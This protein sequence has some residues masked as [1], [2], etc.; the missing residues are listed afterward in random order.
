MESSAT[1]SKL[2]PEERLE[3]K[4]AGGGKGGGGSHTPVETPD[5]LRSKAYANVLDLVCEGPIKGPSKP[6]LEWVYLDGVP[7][8]NPDGSLNFKDVSVSWVLGTQ[9]QDYIPNFSDVEAEIPVATEVKYGTPVVRTISDTMYDQV[10]VTLSVP[11][12]ASTNVTN[13]DISGTSV[14]ILIDVQNNGAGYVNKITDTI[15]GK[16][17]NGY[18][19]SYLIKLPK[20]GGPWDIRVTRVT[21]DSGS[22]TLQN[23]TYWQRYTQIIDQ[24]FSYPNS[25]IIGISID[26]EQFQ[27]IPN[28]GYELDLLLCKVPD[29]Y[30]P[31]TRSYSGT[32]GGGW[33]IAWTNNPVWCTYDFIIATR[34]GCGRRLSEAN[35]DKYALY[36]IAQY[37]DGF[38]ATGSLKRGSYTTGSVT[39][40]ARAVQASV[41]ASMVFGGSPANTITRSSGSW[42]TDGYTVGDTILITGTAKNNGYFTIQTK[43][44][45]VLTVRGVINSE[46]VSCTVLNTRTKYQ[47]ARTTGSFITDGFIIGD[48]ITT[49]GFVIGSNNGRSRV[50]EVSALYL[51]VDERTLTNDTAAAGRTIVTQDPTE[52]RFTCNVYWQVADNAYRTISAMASIF[53]SMAYWGNNMLQFVQDA[54]KSRT[55]IFNN[56]NVKD[57]KF[58]YSS[59]GNKATHTV[60]SVE[61]VDPNNGYTAVIESV[62]DPTGIAI[63]GINPIKVQGVG[64]TSRSQ[65]QRLGRWVLFTERA[66][67]ELVTFQSAFEGMVARPGEIFGVMDN[68]RI[69]AVMSGRIK[70]CP[71]TTHVTL[72]QAVTFAV[73]NTYTLTVFLPTGALQDC[74][75][76]NPGNTTTAS[77]TLTTPLSQTVLV[78]AVFVITS[79]VL[80]PVDYRIL[81]ITDKSTESDIWYEVIGMS[82]A[83]SKFSLVENNLLLQTYGA[84]LLTSKNPVTGV[85]VGEYHVA[86]AKGTRHVV[87][88]GWVQQP[89]AKSYILKWRRNGGEWTTMNDVLSPYTEFE[90]PDVGAID[91][92]VCANYLNG[93]SVSASASY[94]MTGKN[95]APTA[96]TGLAITYTNSGLNFS[97][98]KHTDGDVI[99]YE[100]RTG[101]TAGS[102]AAATVVS[103]FW[104]SNVYQWSTSIPSNCLLYVAA[105]DAS[106]NESAASQITVNTLPAPTGVTVAF[107]TSR[108]V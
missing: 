6:G 83:S 37:C 55:M 100:I 50:L 34:Y 58:A 27:N 36:T 20:P 96:P 81:S 97:W 82:Y 61:W 39:L 46:T 53:R 43:T 66:E 18:E 14:D 67:P 32:W 80:T 16:T 54:P 74:T 3:V 26:S 5:S 76:T 72:D 13:G 108:P 12:L 84:T 95:T 17:T 99:A 41:T 7:L 38:V 79:S 9:T 106:G 73:G 89:G 47:Y 71:D 107:S 22:S 98:D 1:T 65:A 60:A 35:L 68:D 87:T 64:C 90:V 51:T 57:G 77:L 63:Y 59:A 8:E 45:L 21:A 85:T 49:T 105:I 42:I 11:A 92:S 23:K 30:D 91:V 31:L 103:N 2:S 93:V 15:R 78:N 44:D 10:R 40:S 88:V 62:E 101:P 25:A 75:I 29:N 86:S 94:T 52:P 104:G 69:Q 4:G 19:R 102:W 24:K 56:T 28:R 70:A 48:E 33:K